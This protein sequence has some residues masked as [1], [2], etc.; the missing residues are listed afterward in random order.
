LLLATPLAAV[1]GFACAGLGLAN[2]VPVLFGAAGRLPGQQPGAA[3]A[4]TAS[5]GYLGFLVGPP[6]IGFAAQAT[7]LGLALGILVLATVI[8]AV[9]ASLVRIADQAG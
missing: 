2:T 6:L 7:T 5:I 9:F 8:V 1:V 4:A 3:I